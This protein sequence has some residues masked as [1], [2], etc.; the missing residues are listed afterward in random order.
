MKQICEINDNYL[1]KIRTTPVRVF[2][3]RE[4]FVS[5]SR[6][7]MRKT[8]PGGKIGTLRV[9]LPALFALWLSMPEMLHGQVT[10]PAVVSNLSASEVTP[11]TVRLEWTSQADDFTFHVLYSTYPGIEW[12]TSV[13]HAVVP[14]LAAEG[15]R[16]SYQFA[17]LADN[18]MYY[19]R[20]WAYG[21]DGDLTGP[22]NE[23]SLLTGIDMPS[24]VYFDEKTTTSIVASAY[25][26]APSFR[27]LGLGLSGTNIAIEMGGWRW[28]GWHGEG[29]TQKSPM[30]TARARFGI[31]ALGGRIYSLGGLLSSV[32]SSNANEVYDPASDSWKIRSSMPRS[33]RALAAAASGGKVYVFGGYP[34]SHINRIYNPVTDIWTEAQGWNFFAYN[35]AAS[36]GS[37]I[38]V[39]GGQSKFCVGIGGLGM[40]CNYSDLN[41][42]NE[43]DAEFNVVTPRKT[44]ATPRHL[45]AAATVAGRIYVIGG[46]GTDKN[47]EYDPASDNWRGRASM[48]VAQSDLAAA[49]VGRKI[50]VFIGNSNYEYDTVADAWDRKEDMPTYRAGLGAATVGGKVYV[51]GGYNGSVYRSTNEEYD[52]GVAARFDSLTPNTRYLFKA[53]ARNQ[54]GLETADSALFSVYTMATVSL[55][56]DGGPVFTALGG[57]ILRVNWS[58]GTT[59]G[60]FNGE[61]AV[62]QLQVS[63]F[64]DFRTVDTYTTDAVRA[65]VGGL[66]PGLVYNF[67]VKAA[68]GEGEWGDFL[69]LGGT[70]MVDDAPPVSAIVTP[71][72][73]TAGASLPCLAGTVSDAG[74]GVRGVGISTLREI[75]G[76]YF[77]GVAFVNSSE[78]W[79]PVLSS[80]IYPSSWTYCGLAGDNSDGYYRFASRATDVSGNVES[81]S[82]SVR[83]LL[84]RTKPLSTI[85]SPAQR[86]AGEDDI[87]I[88]GTVSDP[89]FTQGIE[90][91][92]SGV[93]PEL[94]WH[95]GKIQLA[96][97][98]DT[99]TYPD[100]T[101]RTEYGQWEDNGYFWSGSTWVPVSAGPVWVDAQYGDE[102]GKWEYHGLVCD[103]AVDAEREAG[104][105]WA[106]GGR[107]VAWS[108][109]TDNA[110]NTEE[111]SS[112]TEFLIARK[113]KSFRLT[114][115]EGAVVAG[116]YFTVHVHA[117]D[118][119]NGEG[120][121]VRNS[122][123]GTVWF[124]VGPHSEDPETM[125]SDVNINDDN[126]LPPPYT[127]SA[128]DYGAK[129]FTVLLKKPGT[130]V[131]TLTDSASNYISG[132]LTI[133][134]LSQY[135]Q[136]YI[137][138]PVGGLLAWLPGIYGTGQGNVGISGAQVSLRRTS[139]GYGWSGTA[140]TAQ[141]KWLDCLVSGTAWE[142]PAQLAR[143]VALEDGL[144]YMAV[145]R[146]VDNLGN[147]SVEYATSV[148][149]IDAAPPDTAVAAP[150]GA[151][152]AGDSVRISGTAADAGAGVKEV[153]VNVLRA[154]DGASWSAASAGWIVGEVWNLASGTA[155]WTFDGLPEKVLFPG[156]TYFALS[157]GVDM[158]GNAGSGGAS[159]STFT[160][161]VPLPVG[162]VSNIS[163]TVRAEGEILWGWAAGSVGG[164]DG[165]AVFS[166]TG[167]LLALIPFRPDGGMYLQTGLSPD[168]PVSVLIGAY[169]YGGY[170]TL[171]ASGT[172]YTLAA[173][174]SGLE[175][176]EVNITSVTLAW[177]L[178]GNPPGTSAMV[179]RLDGGGTSITNGPPFIEGGL[180][181]CSNY[182]FR[183]WNVN[184]G[185]IP[186]GAAVLGPVRTRSNPAPPPSSLMAQPLDGARITLSWSFS[187]SA[188]V[189]RYKLYSDAGKGAIDYGTPI[190]VFSSTVSAW[191][192]PELVPGAEYKFGL[193]AE[194]ACGLEE[195]NTAVVV[196]ARA[197][198]MLSGV[199]AAI[200]TPQTGKKISGNSVTIVADIVQGLPSQIGLVRFQYRLQYS[201]AWEDIPVAGGN[202]PNPDLVAPYFIHWDAS[203]MPTGIYELRAVAADVFGYEDRS[204][205]AITVVVDHADYDTSETVFGG[206]QRKEERISNAVTSTVQAGDNASALVGK[207]VIPAEAV[208]ASTAAVT[209]IANPANKPAPPEY[210]ED[211][212]ATIKINL[213]NGQSQL[214]GGRSALVTLN[215]RDDND[216]GFVDGT[217]A[218][219]ERLGMY[220]AADVGGG[221]TRLPSTVDRK[222]R[223]VSA[224]TTHFS[225]FSLFPA[226]AAAIT[227]VKVFP[228]PWRPGSGGR[229]DAAG[230]AFTGLP[231]SARI[232]LFTLVGEL[233]RALD[234]TASDFGTKIW[235]GNNIAG[236]KVA[237]GIY[238]VRI[239]SGPDERTIKMAVE[240]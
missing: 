73:D 149:R 166:S 148:F 146:V 113:T 40:N 28:A 210:S 194:D 139:D 43:Y 115:P 65:D 225:F 45:L 219:V 120:L 213:S 214:S 51:I 205:A 147:W 49:P 179:E 215:Y 46:S 224:V 173:E 209:L 78:A 189:S 34:Y 208:G 222:S 36:I 41:Y 130:R 38:H 232:M 124:H 4:R 141:E 87:A 101:G 171:S 172:H 133:N 33:N 76:M 86:A 23:A 81:S 170:G 56:Q 134:V 119:L 94:S 109:A 138:T 121:T 6:P 31:A 160:Y 157:R 62:Y 89:G 5:E 236:H 3:W 128:E 184:R 59:A 190:A 206:H 201:C 183:V 70:T 140:W 18:T 11:G 35:A 72:S 93:Y 150:A 69:V 71:S 79:L 202:H 57:G 131:L 85:T 44:F 54:S 158:L 223:T 240:R 169:N 159:R 102:A 107:Y 164:A 168:T 235:D 42:N 156:G 10:A 226:P 143:R 199:H 231:S 13:P 123:R 135:P 7:S 60:G 29:W 229:F 48:P 96:I 230:V 161:H 27:N 1:L 64:T 191:T 211:L 186:T 55:P 177:G 30:P 111:I 92:G 74:T 58:S 137:S 238:L 193:R 25:A 90:G 9:M 99:A 88:S 165:Y 2:T 63:S 144:E 185:N 80:N 218:S 116:E 22:S 187:P 8:L 233:V 182:Y 68:N 20:L 77:D 84:D 104:K 39:L 192:S 216:D 21:P 142:Y 204:P 19:F 83:F 112:G 239:K 152:V 180:T 105:C 181:A 100:V 117:K 132:S 127:F 167:G 26:P 47:E 163:G 151:V 207:V 37:R 178:N 221:W 195:N 176:V 196:S 212:N 66:A 97:F 12:S 98:M 136:V 75:S 125:G 220:T 126:G 129:S 67:R 118:G 154:S 15:G 200:K 122:Y 203:A 53:R 227:G 14:A 188:V 234:V 155:A 198:G 114:L 82:V 110:G 95:Q 237:S 103:S 16:V 61:G 106:Q 162:A 24:S 91:T 50:Y 153:W 32:G 197:V 174:P 217:F 17:A 145:A 175:A 108:R 228:N 52:P